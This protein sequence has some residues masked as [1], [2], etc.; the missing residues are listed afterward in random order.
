MQM[1]ETWLEKAE[2]KALMRELDE[3]LEYVNSA[4]LAIRKDGL[5]LDI[6]YKALRLLSFIYA[7]QAK[8]NE[9]EQILNDVI[10]AGSRAYGPHAADAMY[11]LAKNCLSCQNYEKAAKWCDMALDWFGNVNDRHLTR[12]QLCRNLYF[13]ISEGQ[14]KSKEAEQWRDRLHPDFN[15]GKNSLLR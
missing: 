11:M 4:I 13:K 3:A 10:D 9:A 14:G 12:V 6:V 1:V 8:W 2:K 15:R 5:C 7:G